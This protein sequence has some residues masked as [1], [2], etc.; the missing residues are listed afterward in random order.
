[1]LH[2][3]PLLLLAAPPIRAVPGADRVTHVP[4]LDALASL[5]PVSE[6]AGAHTVA[7]RPEAWRSSTHPLLQF[8][9]TS[10][11]SLAASGIDPKGALT[12]S[13]IGDFEVSCVTLVDARKH[14]EALDAR[15]ARLGDLFRKTDKDTGATLV[16]AR[17]VLGRV[18][19]AYAMK[20]N[21]ACAVT[22]T[23]LGVE[24]VMP[25][26]AR[27]LVAPWKDEALTLRAGLPGVAFLFRPASAG[28]SAVGAWAEGLTF[29]ADAAVA[30]PGLPHLDGAGP[31]PFAALQPRGLGILKL[32]LAKD[33]LL[34][35][36]GTVEPNLPS[37]RFLGP[38]ARELAPVL[39]GKVAVALKE[40][41]VTQ[42]VRTPEARF[43]ALHF[44][45]VAEVT[46]PQAAAHVLEALDPRVLHFPEGTLSVGVRGRVVYLTNDE[47]TLGALLDDLP[48]GAGTQAHGLEA[49]FDPPRLA[50]ALGG[51]PLLEMVQAPELAGLLAASLEVGPLFLGTERLTLWGDRTAKGPSRTQLTWVLKP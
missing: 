45:V 4:R 24:R 3:L 11:D 20:G 18:M 43:F 14:A 49:A 29:H 21:E 17:E 33:A 26:L 6:A 35:A 19:G 51:V 41:K 46:D 30:G 47:P 40:L 48:G 1:M 39:T 32:R 23:G 38:V 36:I 8:D 10:P 50:K 5:V 27:V 9:V 42:G 34:P 25:G 7:L 31:S 22:G 15:L 12:V 13:K 44:A 37:G 16:G 28:A 2:L